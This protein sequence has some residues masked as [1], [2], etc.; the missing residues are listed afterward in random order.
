[1]VNTHLHNKIFDILQNF[2]IFGV[3]MS[4]DVVEQVKI[5]WI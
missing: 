2:Q 1:M 5:V 4:R 3:L